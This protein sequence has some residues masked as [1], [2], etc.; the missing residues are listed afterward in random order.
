MDSEPLRSQA[1]H[2]TCQFV[3]KAWQEYENGLYSVLRTSIPNT[4]LSLED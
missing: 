3:S 4:G 1:A 2:V